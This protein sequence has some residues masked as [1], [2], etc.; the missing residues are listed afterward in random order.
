MN[1]VLI[2][3]PAYNEAKYLKNVLFEIFDY[4][5]ANDILVV[6]DGSNDGSGKIAKTCGVN[7]LTLVKNRGKGAALIRA[8]E[9]AKENGY[10]WVVCMDSDGQ[11]SA[12]NLTDFFQHRDDAEATM[13]LGNR[14]ERTQN[15][16]FHRQLSNGMTSIIIS[17]LCGGQRIHDS[18]CGYRAIRTSAIDVRLLS[19]KGFQLESELLI[20]VCRNGGKVREI[21]IATVYGQ[22]SSS[23]NLIADTLKFLRL[24]CRYLWR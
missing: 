12:N 8:F 1:R 24:A 9:Y 5:P 16:P 19:E 3:L 18:Q 23:I 17:L 20:Q 13:I 14:I 10:A 2:A 15:M 21:P 22:E 7:V 4:A 11:H 6:D